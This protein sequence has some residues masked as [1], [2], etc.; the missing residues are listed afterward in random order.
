[1]SE[2]MIAERARIDLKF[3]AK[4][5]GTKAFIQIWEAWK[6]AKFNYSLGQGN[7]NKA[8]KRWYFRKGEK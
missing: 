2:E 7:G 5:K 6:K 8:W 3:V 4:R 1:M